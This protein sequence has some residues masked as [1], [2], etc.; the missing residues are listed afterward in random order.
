M[1]QNIRVAKY[2]N[3]HKDLKEDTV[4]CLSNIDLIDSHNANI[5]QFLKIGDIFTENC[6][7]TIKRTIFFCD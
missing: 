2:Y 3:K 6:T 1:F 4:Y 5:E 7:P